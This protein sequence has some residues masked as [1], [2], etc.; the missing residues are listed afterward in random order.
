M[1][2]TILILVAALAVAATVFTTRVVARD[3]YAP[4]PT[5]SSR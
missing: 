5:R 4:V 2:F 3:G 1:T